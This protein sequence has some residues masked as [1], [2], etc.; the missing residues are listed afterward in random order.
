MWAGRR[1]QET[2]GKWRTWCLC[3]PNF[4]AE[5][6]M[7]ATYDRGQ[8]HLAIDPQFQFFIAQ[9]DQLPP[10]QKGSTETIF[11]CV[12]SYDCPGKAGDAAQVV[13]G[14]PSMPKPWVQFPAP[15]NMDML[16]WACNL[17]SWGI[18]TRWSETHHPQATQGFPAASA[19]ATRSLVRFSVVFCFCFC[20][21]FNFESIIH[22]M[23]LF[24]FL[25][26][27]TPI[28]TS[29]FSLKSMAFFFINC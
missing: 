20:N 10:L 9:P 3:L 4:T 6:I 26:P 24:P 22:I 5:R 21:S 1:A 12:T 28:Y 16:A 7:T 27:N 14:F 29:V 15:P 25:P 23:P 8:G 17:R 11:L 2:S 13:E 19:S 18:K